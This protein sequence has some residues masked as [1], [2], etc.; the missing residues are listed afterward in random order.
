[1]NDVNAELRERAE[2]AER[3]VGVLTEHL[4]AAEQRDQAAQEQARQLHAQIRQLTALVNGMQA[5]LATA[6]TNLHKALAEQA[7]RRKKK[8]KAEEADTPA[9]QATDAVG[10][11]QPAVPDPPAEHEEP[12]SSK[13]RPRR[14][15]TLPAHLPRHI[16]QI[17]VS[18]CGKC[19]GEDLVGVGEGEV[20]ERYDYVPA[21]IRVERIERATCRC[22]NCGA[23]TT[24]P[25]P[26]MAVPG[27]SMSA[28]LLAHI[29]Y[30]KCCMHLTLDRIAEDLRRLGAD[31]P[32][33][34][35]CDAMGHVANLLDPV[36][37]R[38]IDDLFASGLLHLDGTGVK[39][40]MP[41]EPGS[42][43]GQFTVLSNAEATAYFFSETK[44]GEH[45]AGFLR[46]GT[47]RA[48]RG[49]L[50]ADAASNMD[51]L[52][53]DGAIVECGCWYHARDKY[54]E[55][56]VSAPY[57]AEGGIA[58]IASLFQIEHEADAAGDTPEAR[59]VRR[60]SDSRAVLDGFRKWMAET[61]PRFDPDEE[62]WKAV[63]YCYNHWNALIR[64]L[65]DGRIPLT[66]NQAERDLGPIGRGRKAWL[67]AGSDNGG[68]RLASI[69][70]V[71][72]TCLRLDIDPRV[73]LTDVLPRLSSVPANR[74]RGHL[75]TL[76]PKAWKAARESGPD[77]P[78]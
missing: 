3:F 31:F 69:Y 52:Y 61:Q 43:R 38:I 29:A 1:V 13:R 19:G 25:M 15:A 72:G 56:R 35:M 39:V 37:D 57:E 65:D 33:S 26:P 23:F 36:C 62:L 47:P 58:W 8:P 64:F 11:Q 71:V 4:R 10:E 78:Q 32:V 27:G 24:A 60:S 53:A 76:V 18:R 9:E 68:H 6:L 50:V 48:Y 45:I 55:A 66:N 54:V 17:P 41:G 7:A 14:P 42:Y 16:V 21:Q 63:Q 28:A 40:L 70:T 75:L 34:T 59:K 22:R 30:N 74:G 44:A 20:S 12:V 51:L 73:Y 2:A 67:F 77:P 5:Q 46:V 49:Y